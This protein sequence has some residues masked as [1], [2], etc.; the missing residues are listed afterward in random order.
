MAVSIDS[1]TLPQPH[2]GPAAVL[3]NELDASRF[4]TLLDDGQCRVPRL[5]ITSFELT[6]GDDA[7]LRRLSEVVLR[8]VQKAA[9]GTALSGCDHIS[10]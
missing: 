2:P 4:K 5:S 8:P 6:N 10:F 3:G 1:R 9:S 7:D